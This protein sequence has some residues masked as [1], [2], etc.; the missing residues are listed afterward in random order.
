MHALYYHVL[1]RQIFFVY[2]QFCSY[3]SSFCF[4]HQAVEIKRLFLILAAIHY[5]LMT[6]HAIPTCYF[7]SDATLCTTITF[8]TPYPSS[9]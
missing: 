7:S 9:V 8:Y 6:F 2:K 5:R 3:L 1:Q 4:L